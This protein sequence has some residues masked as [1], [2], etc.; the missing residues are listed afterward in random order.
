MP[1][2]SIILPNYN[3]AKYL[4]ERLD[5]IFNQSFQDFEVILL[6][7]CST[8]NSVEILEKYT[9]HPKVS[10]FIVNKVNSGS[11]FKQWK[12]G[13]DLASGEYIWI[14]ESDDVADNDFLITMV[15]KM[16]SDREIVLAYCQSDKIDREGRKIGSWKEQTKDLPAWEKDFV[17]SGIEIIKSNLIYSNLIPNASAVICRK[18][19][20]S[21]QNIIDLSYKINGDWL[22]WCKLLRNKKLCFTQNTLNQCRFHKA[23][24]SIKNISNFNNIF[25]YYKLLN[26]CYYELEIKFDKKKLANY[27][28]QIWIEQCKNIGSSLFNK[29]F[30]K[31]LIVSLKF[32]LY[33][34]RRIF[35]ILVQRI[36]D[37]TIRR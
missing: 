1:K 8:D 31:V 29:Y 17:V 4:R 26:T 6:D 3:H 12:K 27:V 5:S 15:P 28:F 30:L 34:F 24:G 22:V 33:L 35:R 32:D 7:D 11:T 18:E 23:K 36:S 14:A 2:V 9:K 10:H 19:N 16:E 20:I 13:I 25:E 37:K 21:R